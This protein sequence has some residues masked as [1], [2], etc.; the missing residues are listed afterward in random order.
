MTSFV[1][2]HS[3]KVAVLL[4]VDVVIQQCVNT[5][6]EVSVLVVI[7][8]CRMPASTFEPTPCA[9]RWQRRV[10]TRW[11]RST[12]AS[13]ATTPPPRSQLSMDTLCQVAVTTWRR[14]SVAR[15]RW[16]CPVV[17]MGRSQGGEWSV[18]AVMGPSVCLVINGR[19]DRAIPSVAVAQVRD[20]VR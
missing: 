15:A 19:G 16:Q 3:R 8:K 6:V 20:H 11:A 9:Q 14:E 18:C 5:T 13:V 4:W 12:V 2:L 17:G 7:T 10:Q 1:S